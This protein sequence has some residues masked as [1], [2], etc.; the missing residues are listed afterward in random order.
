MKIST[1]LADNEVVLLEVEGDVD[2]YTARRLDQA[3]ND[4]LAQGHSR[5]VVDA[6]QLGFISSAGLRAIM[7]AEREACERGGQV[8][9]CG[10]N[11]QARRTFEMAGL[12]EY[13]HLSG[14][15]QEA[16]QGW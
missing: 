12:D 7:F 14:T 11:P 13:L 4:H 2:A 3:L 6:S 1:S 16:L 8:R 15:R 9:V 10:L 5:I